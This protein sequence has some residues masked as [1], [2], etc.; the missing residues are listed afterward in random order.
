M[1]YTG[2][3]AQ[4]G[5]GSTLSIGAT[6]TLVGEVTKLDQSGRKNQTQSTTNLS[7]TS[8]EFLG[9]IPD[10]GT[11]AVEGN[12][13]GADAGQVLMETAFQSGA[14]TSFAV[15]LPKTPAQSV[16]GDKWTFTAIVEQLDYAGL[17]PKTIVTFKAQLKVSGTPVFT[18]G[19]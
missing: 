14:L 1:P 11:W 13:I 8:E 3:L 10:P 4:A 18:A 16:A 2:S 6:P 19:S 5:K 9:T 7:S 17:A 12:R 15:Q